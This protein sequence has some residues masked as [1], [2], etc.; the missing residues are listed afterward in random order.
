VT[1]WEADDNSQRTAPIKSF[2]FTKS[3]HRGMIDDLLATGSESARFLVSKKEPVLF[4]QKESW[5]DG[6][7]PDGR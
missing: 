2:R 6:V 5:S 7:D 4:R 3:A 1:N